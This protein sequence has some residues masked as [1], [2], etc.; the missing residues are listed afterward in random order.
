MAQRGR[1][2]VGEV[3]DVGGLGG[4]AGDAAERDVEAGGGQGGL[5]A[6]SSYE[7]SANGSLTVV[8]GSAPTFQRAACWLVVTNDGRY[9][10]TG[11]AASDSISGFG[12]GTDGSLSLLSPDGR[13]GE[14]NAGATD[15]AL[16]MNSQFLYVRNSRA[17]TISGF[18][19]QSDGSLQKLDDASELPSGS[20]GLAAY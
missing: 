14:T 18:A 1:D 5:S 7:V 4:P 11:N 8:S 19:V 15:M 3:G 9:A 16:S 13:S 17:G 12:I 20:A 2:L 10:Y 6:A